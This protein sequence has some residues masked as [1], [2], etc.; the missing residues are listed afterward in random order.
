MKPQATPK[1]TNRPSNRSHQPSKTK[2]YHGQT[3]TRPEIKPQPAQGPKSHPLQR[4]NSETIPN[5]A[6]EAKLKNKLHLENNDSK[7]K[8]EANKDNKNTR[9][10]STSDDKKSKPGNT[11]NDK[12]ASVKTTPS[13]EAV[14]KKST[15]SDKDVRNTGD[16]LSNPLVNC[17]L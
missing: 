14:S 4:A 2:T 1:D 11:T 12:P 15:S 8:K 5:L 6:Q 13:S 9:K 7:S 16:K 17:T 3:H 10:P